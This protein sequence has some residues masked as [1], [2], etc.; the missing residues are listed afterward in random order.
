[1]QTSHHP[2]GFRSSC[3]DLADAFLGICERLFA[4]NVQ[5]MR[6]GGQ[7]IIC[8]RRVR[9]ADGNSI[10]TTP[11]IVASLV[12]L[13]PWKQ[14]LR[15]SKSLR[16]RIEDFGD[17]TPRDARIISRVRRAR[18][19]KTQYPDAEWF[20]LHDTDSVTSRPLFFGIGII[21]PQSA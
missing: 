8:M 15:V 5:A 1:M 10:K 14:L 21:V 6:Q 7:N 12:G 18:A 4:E 19:T 16:F 20:V 3:F 17:Y 9:R 13:D 11:E 2:V